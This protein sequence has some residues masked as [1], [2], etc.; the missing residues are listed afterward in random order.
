MSLPAKGTPP[1]L[2]PKGLDAIP[3]HEDTV[4]VKCTEVIRGCADYLHMKK[5]S[6]VGEIST[7]SSWFHITPGG[8]QLSQEGSGTTQDVINFNPF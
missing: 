4:L 5:F 1:A 7:S 3:N 6:P 2:Q 8:L